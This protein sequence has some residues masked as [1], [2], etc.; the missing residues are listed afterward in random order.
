MC[1]NYTLSPGLFSEV[2]DAVLSSN[3]KSTVRQYK[4]SFVNFAKWCKN[5]DLPLLPA[6]QVTVALYLVSI[7]QR[8]DTSYSKSKVNQVLYAINWAH[9]VN[10]ATSNHCSDNWLKLCLEGCLGKVSNL[11]HWLKNNLLL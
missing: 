7:V 8:E 3:E 6:S 2:K 11:N 1:S 9:L 10:G 5:G 4:N